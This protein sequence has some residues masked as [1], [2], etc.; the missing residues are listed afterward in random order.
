MKQIR[1][2]K[3]HFSSFKA[4]LIRETCEQIRVMPEKKSSSD[5]MTLS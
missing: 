3:F 2:K 5:Q 1:T 4:N